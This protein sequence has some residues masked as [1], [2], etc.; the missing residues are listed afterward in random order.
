[1]AGDKME[2][3]LNMVNIFDDKS[4]LLINENDKADLLKSMTSYNKIYDFKLASIHDFNVFLEDDY[5]MVMKKQFL[6]DPDYSKR[7]IPYFNYIDIAKIYHNAKLQFLVEAASYLL[8]ENVMKLPDLSKLK[9]KNIISINDCRLPTFV[10]KYHPNVMY[11]SKLQCSSYRVYECENKEKE[12]EAVF[13]HITTLLEQKTPID[14]IHVVNATKEDV[15]HIQKQF[16][17]ALIPYYIHFKKE[18]KQY[19]LVISFMKSFYQFGILGSIQLLNTNIENQSSVNCRLIQVVMSIINR[20]SLEDI[21]SYQDVFVSEINEATII[22]PLQRQ[23]VH[24]EDL[25]GL[26]IHENDHY[27]VMN[28]HDQSLPK[29]KKDDDYLLDEEKQQVGMATSIE[30]NEVEKTHLESILS[31]IRYLDCFYSLNDG[32]KK[33]RMAILELQ[34]EIVTSKYMFFLRNHSY[35]EAF[36]FLNYAK[37][38]YDKEVFGI[39]KDAFTVYEKRFKDQLSTYNS[40]FSGISV[41]NANQLIGA[42]SHISATSLQMFYECPFHYMLDYLL[43]LRRNE[44]SIYLFFGNVTHKILE[45]T[46]N[47]DTQTIETILNNM[48]STFPSEIKEKMNIYFE[49]YAK[50]QKVIRNYLQKRKEETT[51]EDF[52]FEINLKYVYPQDS[53]FEI[54]GKIDRVMTKTINDETKVVVIDYKTG[55]ASFSDSDFEKGIEPQLPFYLHLLEKTKTINHMSPLGFYYQKANLGRLN[56][57]NHDDPLKKLLKLNGKTLIDKNSVLEFDLGDNIQ[58][59]SFKVNGEFKKS[60]KLITKDDMDKVLSKIDLL[61]SQAIQAILQGDFKIKPVMVE[62]NQKISKSCEYCPHNAIC[63]I[64]STNQIDTE[65]DVDEEGVEMD[66]IYN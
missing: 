43:K 44:E 55:Q 35:L 34:R 49:V 16:N 30:E 56:K 1:M 45:Q 9:D 65:D 50:E 66:E 4:L 42:C 40:Q 7:L 36:D 18:I 15:Y 29:T 47:N 10:R 59:V 22:E 46:F 19:P 6:L 27:L 37:Q 60:S 5:L 54:V 32:H 31:R 24:F 63:Y 11:I 39:T 64:N 28:F 12:I 2:N 52:G 38:K 58:G 14:S 26:N 13:T 23:V 51:F 17:D 41:K 33:R 61:I 8:L 21:D 3:I 53:R 20:Y 62:K 48:S 25:E 57:D